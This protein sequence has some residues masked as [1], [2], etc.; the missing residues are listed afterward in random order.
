[1]NLVNLLSEFL[2]LAFD[3]RNG[4]DSDFQENTNISLPLSNTEHFRYNE[5]DEGLHLM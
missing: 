1:M 5:N 2:R 4:I 3:Q